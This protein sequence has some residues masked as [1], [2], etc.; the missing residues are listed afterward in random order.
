[1]PKRLFGH[2]MMNAG[3]RASGIFWPVCLWREMNRFA[4]CEMCSTVKLETTYG[5]F[6]AQPVF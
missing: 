1:M 2:G 4:F 5:V 3:L 6:N